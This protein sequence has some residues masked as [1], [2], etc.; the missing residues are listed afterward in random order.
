MADFDSAMKIRQDDPSK[1]QATVKGFGT[2]GA[3][4]SGVVTIQGIAGMTPLKVQGDSDNADG[5]PSGYM[6][7]AADDTEVALAA[8]ASAEVAALV[9]TRAGYLKACAFSAS[10]RAKFEVFIGATFAAAVTAGSVWIPGFTTPAKPADQIDF[11]SP[12]PVAAGDSAFVRVRN[13]DKEAMDCYAAIDGY[14]LLP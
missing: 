1:L 8:N 3:P 13:D 5:V 9:F 11:P 4:D 2:A 7:N 12:I 14:M 6:R 10:G